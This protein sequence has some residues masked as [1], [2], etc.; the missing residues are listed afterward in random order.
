MRM[1][2]GTGKYRMCFDSMIKAARL[3]SIVLAIVVGFSTFA[4]SNPASAPEQPPDVQEFLRLLGKGDVQ[5]FLRAQQ[6]PAAGVS[7]S[8]VPIEE[9]SFSRAFSERLAQIRL[10][11]VDLW[12]VI[13]R[14]GNEI[15]QAAQTVR[16]ATG[17]SGL[18]SILFSIVLFGAL[19]LGAQAIATRWVKPDRGSM[20][21]ADQNAASTRRQR[22]GASIVRE[23]VGVLAFCVVCFAPFILLDRDPLSESILLSFL[24]AWTAWVLARAVASVSAAPV[25]DNPSPGYRARKDHVCFWM[26]IAA[27]WF[28]L[29]SAL[30]EA[31]RLS[32]MDLLATDLVSYVLGSGLLAIGLAAIWRAPP[33]HVAS[34]EFPAYNYSAHRWLATLFLI[35]L[36]TVWVADAVRLFWLLAIGVVTPIALGAARRLTRHL[37]LTEPDDGTAAIASTSI[38]VVDTLLRAA[39]IG[40][41]LWVLAIAWGINLTHL[42][43]PNDPISKVARALLTVLAIL[44]AFDVLWQFTKTAIDLKIAKV[45]ET[46]TPGSDVGIRQAKLRTLLPVLRN[47]AMVVF[48]TLAVLMA[49]STLGVEIGPLIASAGVVG[50][51]IGFGAQTLVKDVISGIF[52]LLD[53][54]FRVG[55]YIISGSFKGTVESFSLRSIRLR[56]HN[57]PVYTIPFSALG[58]VQNVSRDYAVDKLLITVSY[59]TDLEKARKMIRRVGEQLMEDPELAPVIIEPLKM[60]AVSDFGTY[61]IQLKLKMTTKP[62]SQSAVRKKAFPLIKKAFD[63]SGIEFAHP[64]VKVAEGQASAQ[65]AASQQVLTASMAPA[66]P[67]GA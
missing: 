40:M 56:H 1:G 15:Q 55:E 21:V 31:M 37:S 67:S 52:Y 41:A 7:F 2:P 6:S 4:F 43:A 36:W 26:V 42:T 23:L 25:E 27:G 49:L 45:D 64:T 33:M 58:A 5:D 57:G 60:Q 16:D 10:R 22:L 65:L 20:I 18:F 50:L 39:L 17:G 28:A 12:R 13:P 61:G 8:R 54:A 38:V 62:G 51:A 47:F 24:V 48:A 3:A 66:A 34:S 9:A 63:D 29:G 46:A 35:V 53:D 14:L 32:G 59:D 44:F 30:V 11:L 19:G